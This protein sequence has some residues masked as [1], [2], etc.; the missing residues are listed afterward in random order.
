MR[1]LLLVVVEDSSDLRMLLSIHAREVG[2]VA[3]S[4]ATVKAAIRWAGWDTV[5]GAV[6]DWRLPDGTGGDLLDW[7]AEHHPH[8]RCV[9]TTALVPLPTHPHAV[10]VLDK[11]DFRGVMEALR[12]GTRR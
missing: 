4:F 3:A 2:R 9:V 6:I 11:A 8:V 5:D 10:A 7:L 12:E 1:G